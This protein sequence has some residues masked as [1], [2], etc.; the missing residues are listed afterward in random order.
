MGEIGSEQTQRLADV[1]PPVLLGLAKVHSLFDASPTSLKSSQ[2]Y[3][4]GTKV[5]PHR[6][7]TSV[8]DEVSLLAR[9]TDLQLDRCISGSSGVCS[10]R[11]SDR[12]R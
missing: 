4:R 8:A 9:Q 5:Q 7:G 1:N 6:F 12:S 10:T 3:S 11:A 2:S